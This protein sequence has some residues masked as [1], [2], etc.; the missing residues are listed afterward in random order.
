MSSGN[1]SCANVNEESASSVL[2]VKKSLLSPSGAPTAI[3][4]ETVT[5][6][7]RLV[8]DV[9]DV[10]ANET[11]Q[12]QHIYIYTNPYY[13]K[14]MM[15]D[16]VIQ[17]TSSDEHIYHEMM[18]HVALQYLKKV[19]APSPTPQ[20]RCAVVG[21]GDGGCLREV[22][23]HQDAVKEVTLVEIDGRVVDLCRTHLPEVS[24]GAF[25]HEKV[26]VEIAD[27]AVWLAEPARNNTL[28]LLVIDSSDDD[29]DSADINS[30]LFTDSFYSKAFSALN[31]TGMCYVHRLK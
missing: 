5:P 30:S 25:E 31:D 9:H 2:N 28:D 23:K 19:I 14:V 1:N 12:W 3:A 20:L 10:L 6:N 16:S 7:S 15:L 24:A 4:T 22:L 13:G 21:G 29:A 18:V 17:C 8:L 26:K 27:G 11:S